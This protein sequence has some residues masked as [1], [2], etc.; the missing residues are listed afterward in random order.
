VDK[1]EQT[2]T[3]E[4]KTYGWYCAKNFKS[5]EYCR[6]IRFKRFGHIPVCG[7]YGDEQLWEGEDRFIERCPKCLNEFGV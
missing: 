2:R 7:L 4:F 6:F 1:T 5:G 3:L